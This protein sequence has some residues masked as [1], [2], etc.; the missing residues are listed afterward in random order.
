LRQTITLSHRPDFNWSTD[1]DPRSQKQ[2]VRFILR[3]RR[4]PSPAMAVAEASLA[5]VEEAVAA[6][7]RST[8]RRGSVSTH[9]STN[10]SEIRSL[11]RY[12]DALLG[13]LLEIT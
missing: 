8:Y 2:K 7:A 1:N 5:T 10:G 6:L 12:V 13:E 3:A 9:T 11:K 4:S